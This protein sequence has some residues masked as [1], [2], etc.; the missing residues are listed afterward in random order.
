V[1]QSGLFQ[2]PARVAAVSLVLYGCAAVPV[3][4]ERS[5]RPGTMSGQ[6]GRPGLVIAAPHG[7]SDAFT[8]EIAAEIARRTGFGLVV[9]SDFALE[10]DRRER[11]GRRFQVNR[12]TEG[13]P[14]RPPGEEIVSDAARHAY[15]E[16]ER[17]VMDVARGQLQLYVEIH[18]NGR[19]LSAGQLEIATV[20]L[21]PNDAWRVRTLLELVRDARLR[22]QPDAPR[23][24]VLVQPIDRIRYLASGAKQAGILRHPVR[25]LHIEIPRSAR[26]EW[27]AVYTDVLAQFLSEAVPVLTAPPPASALPSARP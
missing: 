1:G 15:D 22:A 20:G 21:E 2:R 10:P 13:I 3:E 26:T 23:L 16:F 4:P 18:G 8:G 25:A 6:R 27:R 14:G 24:A 9:A 11:V 17:R 5:P 7:T 19:R 12:P